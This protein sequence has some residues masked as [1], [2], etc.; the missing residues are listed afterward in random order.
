[1]V[2]SSLFGFVVSCSIRC[3]AGHFLPRCFSRRLSG[4][5][6][7]C[8]QDKENRKN[9]VDNLS[10]YHGKPTRYAYVENV[11]DRGCPH[12]VF[13]NKAG[14]SGWYRGFFME[15]HVETMDKSCGNP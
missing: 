3:W 14:K 9:P 7:C 6:N 2:V 8:G 15:N 10:L 11:E 4:C 1:M 5:G 13:H 12:R